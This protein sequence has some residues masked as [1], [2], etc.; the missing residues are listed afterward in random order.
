MLASLQLLVS[1]FVELLQEV[2]VSVESF[3][4]VRNLGVVEGPLVLFLCPK[5]ERNIM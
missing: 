2:I 1:V 5:C 3:G 4:L